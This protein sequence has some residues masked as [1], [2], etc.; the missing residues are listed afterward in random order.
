[1]F[2]DGTSE[3]S[4]PTEEAAQP[5]SCI[6]KL[7]KTE[8]I[9]VKAEAPAGVLPNGT[10]MIVKAVENNTEDA[11]LTDQYNKLAA[12]ITEQLQSQGKKPR[13]LPC[14]QRIFYRCRWQSG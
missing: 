12:K 1:M 2:T 5:V 8:T 11:E 6:V 14:L 10:Q 3:S 9:E 13:R 7:E 4:T